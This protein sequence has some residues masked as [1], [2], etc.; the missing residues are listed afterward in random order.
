MPKK[1]VLYGVL[2]SR[3]DG[4]KTPD[5]F[6]FFFLYYFSLYGHGN[7]HGKFCILALKHQLTDINVHY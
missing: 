2:L 6:L 4:R 3:R 1:Y 5:L 7:K